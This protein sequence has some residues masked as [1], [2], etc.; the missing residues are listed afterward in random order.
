MPS[1]CP[2]SR[3]MPGLWFSLP[4]SLCNVDRDLSP[5]VLMGEFQ[6]AVTTGGLPTSSPGI[7]FLC[8]P[9]TPSPGGHGS[10]SAQ[11][12]QRGQGHPEPP[13]P[14]TPLGLSRGGLTSRSY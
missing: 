9:P 8:L 2:S 14:P 5:S 13:R 4:P 3:V 6:G 11:E 10:R 1:E 12:G 7:A